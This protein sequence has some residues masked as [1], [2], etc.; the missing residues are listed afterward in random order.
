MIDG[1]SFFDQ[2][3]K[4]DLITYENTRKISTGQ[5]DDY[6]TSCL[7]DYNYFKNY[8]KMKAKDLRKQQ[9][10][11]ADPKA[12]K[13][14][15]CKSGSRRTNGNVFYYWRSKKNRLRFFTRICD[16]VVILF[17]FDIIFV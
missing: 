16:S 9:M 17:C 10:L 8:Y 3:V 5:G 13:Q 1:K 6:T 15:Y 7:L 12:I 11:D 4:N 2:P 14:I